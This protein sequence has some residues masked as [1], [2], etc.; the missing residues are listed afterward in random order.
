MAA[1]QLVAEKPDTL[2]EL[3]FERLNETELLAKVQDY[4]TRDQWANLGRQ[5]PTV[6][7]I[8]ELEAWYEGLSA[9]EK[10]IQR[11][12]L[13]NLMEAAE[14]RDLPLVVVV[15]VYGTNDEVMGVL[16]RTQP[17]TLDVGTAEDRWKIIRHR[18]LDHL[19]NEKAEEVISEYLKAYERVRDLLPTIRDLDSLRKDMRVNYPFHPNF[20][21][22][23]FEVYSLMPRHE[24]TR[25]VVGLCATLLR[26]WAKERDMILAGDLVLTEEEIASDL[27][28]LSPTLVENALNDLQERCHSLSY[29][30]EFLG[31]ILFY[32]IGGQKGISDEDLW[33]ATLR[34]DRNINDLQDALNEVYQAARY[35][36]RQ[37][38]SWLITVEESLEKRIEQEAR[39]LI[40]KPDGRMKAAEWLKER[41]REKMEGEVT[42]YPEEPI[43]SGG[44]HLRYVVAL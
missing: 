11:N 32:S 1:V 41:V 43:Q 36:D 29:S 22:K 16:N 31:A 24:A 4:P 14:L 28:K 2:W 26:R 30:S 12:A 9:D 21:R 37:N 5:Q 7:L 42:L 27:R 6:L 33:L 35:L 44:T 39:L 25:G 40:A 10:P 17:L 3:L 8:D 38:G 15:A 34:P 13:Q 20:L 23:A 19:D 18:L